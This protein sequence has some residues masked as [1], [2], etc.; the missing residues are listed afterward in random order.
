MP[1]NYKIMCDITY[2]VVRDVFDY[3]DG[4]LLWKVR[5]NSRTN[6]GDEAGRI[7][8]FGYRKVGLKGKSYT[9]HSLVWLWCTGVWSKLTLDHIN[10]NRTDNRLEN[11]REATVQENSFNANMQLNN[12]SGFKGVLKMDTVK[13]SYRA[14]ATLNGKSIN[15]GTYSTAELASEAYQTFAKANHGK[16]YRPPPEVL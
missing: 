6:I 13:P 8:I 16:F 15:L 2:E 12:T 4:K 1:S 14:Q 3:Q 5:L 10:G 11:L 9:I 7:T